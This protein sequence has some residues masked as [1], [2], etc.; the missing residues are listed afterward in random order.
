MEKP[1]ENTILIV[2]DQAEDQHILT[3]TLRRLG[4][5]NKIQSLW[6]GHEAI[7]YFNGD[8]PYSDRVKY[9][10]PAI[11]FLDLN[12]PVVSGFDVLDWLRGTSMKGGSHVFIYSEV[13]NVSNVRRIYALGADSFVRK[14]IQE[15]DLMN[16]IFHFPKFWDIKEGSG[17][18]GENMAQGVKDSSGS[19]AK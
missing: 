1:S 16:L 19:R 9:P 4:V 2:D 3:R 15:V 10:L 5:R 11:V 12:L 6:D 18:A 17:E 8:S 14:P 13:G 7:R